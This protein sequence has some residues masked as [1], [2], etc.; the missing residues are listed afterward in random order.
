MWKTL[1]RELIKENVNTMQI[2]IGW[3]FKI[4][5]ANTENINFLQLFVYIKV[6]D[7]LWPRLIEILAVLII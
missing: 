6:F 1:S 2:K 3:L 4:R 7:I 5:H